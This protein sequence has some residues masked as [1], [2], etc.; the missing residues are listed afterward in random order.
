MEFIGLFG[1]D[2][3]INAA[4]MSMDVNFC[5]TKEFVHNSL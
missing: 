2:G 4:N 5:S 3:F 1:Y